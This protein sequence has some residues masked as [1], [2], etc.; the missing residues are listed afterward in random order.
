MKVLKFGGTSVKNAENISK[1]IAIIK[2][3][4]NDDAVLTVV[5]AFGGVTNLLIEAGT[6]AAKGDD[7]YTS[8][9]TEIETRHIETIKTLITSD[10]QTT[11]IN[12]VQ[13][14][15]K[16]LSDLLNGIF[17]IKEFSPRSFDIVVSFGERL[18]AYIISEVLIEQKMN[19]AF[20]DAREVIKTDKNFGSAKV[21]FDITN[22][23]IV[24][25]V[26]KGDTLFIATGFIGSTTD[27]ETT[28]IGRGGSDYSAA[29]FAAAL[30]ASILEIWTD[31]DGMMTADPRK[32]R[33]AYP[34]KNLTYSEAMELSH[35][36]AKVLEPRTVIPAMGKN[37]PVHIKNTFNPEAPGTL[38]TA[39]S[40]D[41]TQRVQGISSIDEISLITVQGSGMIGEVGISMRLF[42]AI[43]KDNINVILITQ[44]SS[45]HSIT[46]AV[47]PSDAEKAKVLLEEEFQVE[48]QVGFIE[49]II[50]E[51]DL[52]VIAAVGENMKNIPGLAGKFFNTL[53]KNG[54]NV[55]AIAQGASELNI[56]V[57]ISADDKYKAIN[58]LH[59][60]F[61]LSE[62]KTLNV[63]VV[64]TGVIGGELLNQIEAQNETL[65]KKNAT[66]VR[67][68]GITN[69]DGTLIEEKG[70]NLA[71]WKDDMKAKGAPSDLD[72]FVEK[73]KELNLR[74]S[75][76]V[77]N[78]GSYDVAGKYEELLAKAVSVVTPNKVAN[79]SDYER[80]SGIHKI[81]T[82]SGARFLYETNVGAGLP[83]I[84][85]LKD[86]VKS[87]DEIL[88]IEAILSGS[89]N[90][91]FSNI[92]STKDFASTVKDARELGYTEPDPKLDL[93][94]MDVARKILI[95]SREIGQ[96]INL[97]DVDIENCLTP[98]SQKTNTVE[99]LWET[100]EKY[101]NP[102]FEEKIKQ[103]E[104]DGKRLKYIATYENGISKTEVKAVGPEHPFY[105]IKGSDNIISFT[106][107]RYK[108]QPLIV[109]GPG[110]GAQV[111]AAGVFAD[112]IRIVNY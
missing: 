100:L 50:V 110:A 82:K 97:T 106:T 31:V 36:G 95:L 56:S 98:E 25:K 48:L 38:I 73:I 91:I 71:T 103:A 104:A 62:V 41:E 43:A 58:S 107:A 79:A 94:G 24:A 101:D 45:E 51:N 109:I 1:A 33:R 46:F 26:G 83:I 67:V 52:T 54:I 12:E 102:V 39:E 68:V 57:V 21:N 66:D 78:T 6:K 60:T 96:K 35:F 63:F 75:V 15:L 87:G 77:D 53:G 28:T 9:V 23:N 76:F 27:N 11:V 64:G 99:E 70:I 20:L 108:T 65:K 92:S 84:N 37:I 2:E 88:K 61:F 69:V 85:T 86:L 89:L 55:A 59:E 90:Y 29:I 22:K 49:E 72:A 16:N 18:S 19:A 105:N 111:T 112:I 13:T 5:S 10:K 40:Q 44:G 74:N 8:I 32:V 4:K 3:K 30:D 17:L 81:A 42:Q 7:T 14:K 80:Y 47:S 34:M 93:A